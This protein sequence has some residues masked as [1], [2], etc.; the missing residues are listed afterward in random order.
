VVKELVALYGDY[1]EIEMD[2]DPERF[3]A[4]IPEAEYRCQLLH[5]MTSGGW[6]DDAFYVFA[7]LCC[8]IRVVRVQISMMIQPYAVHA[9]NCSDGP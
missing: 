9:R 6:Q 1:Q 3:K 7:S 2:M 5:G 8:I 4:L